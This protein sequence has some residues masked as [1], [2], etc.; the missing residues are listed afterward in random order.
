MKREWDIEKDNNAQKYHFHSSVFVAFQSEG[1]FF[2]LP[3]ENLKLWKSNPDL[4]GKS[5][6]QKFAQKSS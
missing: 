5:E 4:K 6:K 1:E 2:A 3:H